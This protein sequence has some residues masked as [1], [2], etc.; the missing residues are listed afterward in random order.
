MPSLSS[1]GFNQ[2]YATHRSARIGPATFIPNMSQ[3]NRYP[4]MMLLRKKAASEI[5][6][7]KDGVSFVFD[8][9]VTD[10]NGSGPFNPGAVASVNIEGNMTQL[11]APHAFYRSHHGWIDTELN[12]AN[13]AGAEAKLYDFMIA[14]RQQGRTRHVNEIDNILFYRPDYATMEGTLSGATPR[15]AY[16]ALAYISEDATR[17]LPPSTSS[18]GS[19]VWGTNG[20]LGVDPTTAANSWHRNAVKN[21]TVGALDHPENGIV[22][23]FDKMAIALT[24]EKPVQ[25]EG[26]LMQDASTT[27]I[28]MYTNT[29]GKARISGL[30]RAAQDKFQ[31]SNDPA[32]PDTMFDG[33]EILYAPQLD[34]ELLEQTT[35]ASANYT[36][37]F[38]TAGKPRFFWINRRHMAPKFHQDKAMKEEAPMK[39]GGNQPDANVV[40][41]NSTINLI[42][43]DR[44]KHGV[45]APA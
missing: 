13:G 40:W 22:A 36:G 31:K 24:Y 11:S 9:Q 10:S 34:T 19:G 7:T 6:D 12:I 41:T 16:S 3:R 37:A 4:L 28:I 26:D 44:R 23:A 18:G 14:K 15:R 42:C 21:Y 29:D 2:L 43:N 20:L 5:L 8:V 45:V 30:Y 39:I 33:I 25:V 38:Y 35:G 1:A 27:D 32:Y 17:Y